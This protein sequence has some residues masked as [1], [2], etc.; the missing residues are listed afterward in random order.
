[1]PF[2]IPRGEKTEPGDAPQRHFTV[3]I[4]RLVKSK[5]VQVLGRLCKIRLT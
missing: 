1:L 4:K 5:A 2:L 3:D